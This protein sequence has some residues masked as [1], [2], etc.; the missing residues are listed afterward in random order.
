MSKQY[1]KWCDEEDHI[2]RDCTIKQRRILPLIPG[3]REKVTG[4]ILN[5]YLI[6][7]KKTPTHI[8]HSVLTAWNYHSYVANLPELGTFR[9]A[10]LDE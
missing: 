3:R 6:E 5:N 2:E 7:K 8:K 9:W 10:D 4:I 1:C